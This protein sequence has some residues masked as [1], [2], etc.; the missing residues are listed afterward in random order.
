MTCQVAAYS[1]GQVKVFE[2]LNTLELEKWQLQ[3]FY[4]FLHIYICVAHL[5]FGYLISAC[6]CTQSHKTTSHTYRYSHHT[7]FPVVEDHSY[8][9]SDL[10]TLGKQY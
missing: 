2:L 10:C 4:L 9:Y 7:M 6:T 8:S 1:S 3:V 5:T